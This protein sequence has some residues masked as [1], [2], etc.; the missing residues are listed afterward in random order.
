MGVLPAFNTDGLL[1]PGDYELTFGEIRSSLL[2]I[3]PGDP[4]WDTSW[5]RWLVEQLEVLMNQLWSVGIVEV[6]VDGSFVECKNR[7]GDID[8]YFVCDQGERRVIE[9]AGKNRF[10]SG[11]DVGP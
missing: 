8:G 1:P 7:P 4:E 3:G 10:R 5:R 2:V 11:L 9:R 6:F